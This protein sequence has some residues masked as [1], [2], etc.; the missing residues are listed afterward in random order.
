MPR[1]V[2]TS[3]AMRGSPFV[4]VDGPAVAGRAV[5]GRDRARLPE[6]VV[7]AEQRRPVAARRGLEVLKLERVGV[8]RADLEALGRAV[9]AADLDHRLA[10]VPRVVQEQRALVA[11]R[12]ELV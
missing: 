4:G 2:F 10:P 11:A 3:L 1:L 6:R 9:G 7:A 5:Q 8:R 12:L